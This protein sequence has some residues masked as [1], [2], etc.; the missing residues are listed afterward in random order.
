MFSA[1][2][3]TPRHPPRALLDPLPQSPLLHRFFAL[4]EQLIDRVSKSFRK[5]STHISSPILT[6]HRSIPNS[7][8]NWSQSMPGANTREFLT[9]RYNEVYNKQ[10]SMSYKNQ[11][12]FLSLIT[13][14]SVLAAADCFEFF[15]LLAEYSL[16]PKTENEKKNQRPTVNIESWASDILNPEITVFTLTGAQYLTTAVDEEKPT[17]PAP[18]TLLK[19]QP[20]PRGNSTPKQKIL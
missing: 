11:C 12:Y 10:K 2:P 20:D 14:F 3:R 9:S 7:T 16:N 1:N 5:A 4:V 17:F 8:M 19:S 15:V 6:L 18:R 13:L